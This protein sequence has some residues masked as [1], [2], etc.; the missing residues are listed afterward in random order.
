MKDK[1]DVNHEYDKDVV[2]DEDVWIGARVTL[3]SGVHIRRGCILCAGAV[4]TKDTPPYA[5][6]GGVPAKLIKY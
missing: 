2:V 5:I 6:I 4:V 3:L 1:L